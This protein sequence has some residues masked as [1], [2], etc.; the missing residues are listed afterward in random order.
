[1]LKQAII[2][3]KGSGISNNLSLYYI[4]KGSISSIENSIVKRKKET[5]LWFKTGQKKITLQ[6]P[7]SEVVIEL[8]KKCLR[9]NIQFITISSTGELNKEFGQKNED[10]SILVL[11]P[12]HENK[13]D[14]IT[15]HL[16]LY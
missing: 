13:L 2:I 5:D 1:M 3:N 8:I 14:K 6:V 16:K 9:A 15:N 7:S 11:G 4:V 12:E 10:Y